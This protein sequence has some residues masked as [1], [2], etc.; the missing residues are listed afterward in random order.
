MNGRMFREK[1]RR[2]VAEHAMAEPGE[3]VLVALSGG[4][5]SVCLLLVLKGMGVEVEAAHCNFHLRGEESM[6]DERFV[7][8]LCKRLGVRLHRTDFDTE[9]EAR[10]RGVSIEMAARDLRYEFFARL[11]AEED[12]CRVLAV[13]HHKDDNAETFLLNAVRKTGLRGLGG[14][15][16]VSRNGLGCR[17]VRPLLCVGREEIVRFLEEEG[18]EWV[19]DSTNLHADV[20][21]NKVRLGVVPVL[22]EINPGAVDTL[23]STMENIAEVGKI[24]DDWMGREKERC[25]RW[26]DERTL[27]IYRESLA[28]SASPISVLHELLYPIGFNE[29]QVRNLLHA[30]GYKSNRQKGEYTLRLPGG[31]EV[32]LEVTWKVIKVVLGQKLSDTANMV[33]SM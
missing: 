3:R 22:K 18:E 30:K 11:M 5:D 12:G 27:Y 10:R 1:V 29:T 21:R 16:P 2:Y 7:V 8:E 33:T 26:K 19:T 23:C 4:A 31:K 14:I 28:R 32:G 25:S 9:G 15:K 24:Y 6:R 13:G 17:V 20:A